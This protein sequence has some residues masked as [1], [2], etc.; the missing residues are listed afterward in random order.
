MIKRHV[1]PLFLAALFV[2]PM[3]PA[4]SPE[5]GVRAAI[6]TLFDGMRAGDSAMVRSV[7]HESAVLRRAAERDGAPVLGNNPADGFVRAIGRPHDEIWNEQVWDIVVQ[8]DDRLATAWMKFAFF[9][10]DAFSHCGVNAMQF[11]KDVDGWKIFSIA[12]TSRR[13]DC[14]MPPER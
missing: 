4:Q 12:D 13:E 6:Q 1:L 10:G 9:R 8:V 14:W 11:F 7:L 2:P 3:L 5:D